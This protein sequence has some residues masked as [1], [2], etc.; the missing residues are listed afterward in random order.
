MTINF[1]QI[2]AIIANRLLHQFSSVAGD[3]RIPTLA[4]LCQNFPFSIILHFLSLIYYPNVRHKPPG[5][6]QFP[7]PI[8]SHPI[9]TNP[10]WF[11]RAKNRDI[12]NG[13]FA[14]PLSGPFAR[15]PNRCLLRSCA[16]LRSLTRSLARYL[17][18][19]KV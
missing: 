5:R 10:Q 1:S 7:S 4:H 14:R 6:V 3:K 16:P 13:L 8:P 2:N 12:M 15:K 17:A 9:L 19:G 11:S 18:H